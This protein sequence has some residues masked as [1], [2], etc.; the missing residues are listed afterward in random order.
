MRASGSPAVAGTPPL[1]HRCTSGGTAAKPG[2]RSWLRASRRPCGRCE[3]K[4]ECV[5]PTDTR[6]FEGFLAMR[7]KER[8]PMSVSGAR[9]AQAAFSGLHRDRRRPRPP[10]AL[11]ST[12]DRDFGTEPEPS[13]TS[14]PR[15]SPL[16][17]MPG[18]TG[19]GDHWNEKP[20]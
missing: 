7:A 6:L 18:R 4:G 2:M 20:G 13:L 1:V 10:R 19:V 3:L 9:R 5:A 11:C 12:P 16:I 14:L 17:S 15:A 8:I